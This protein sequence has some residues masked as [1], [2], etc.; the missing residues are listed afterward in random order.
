MRNLWITLAILLSAHVAAQ[1]GTFDVNITKPAY[2]S[3][4][5]PD[6]NYK[7]TVTI[8]SSKKAA[9]TVVRAENRRLMVEN[10]VTRR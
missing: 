8:G 3:V 4:A 10:A 1:T 2:F 7:V 9:N 5:V 6:G